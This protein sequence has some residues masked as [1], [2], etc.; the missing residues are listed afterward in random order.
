MLYT[1]DIKNGLEQWGI[2]L[3]TAPSPWGPWSHP[4]PAF[5]FPQGF[6]SDR[7]AC[8]S[9]Q[10][11]SSPNP[12]HDGNREERPVRSSI[13]RRNG[14]SSYAPFLLPSRYAR[15]QSDGTLVLFYTLSTWN[16]YQ[17]VL[18]RADVSQQ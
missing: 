16:P 10:R 9:R 14:G 5:K 17:T 11:L 12:Y 8:D 1:S 7:G 3:R 18:M 2:Y 6:S 4:V 13:V 15:V